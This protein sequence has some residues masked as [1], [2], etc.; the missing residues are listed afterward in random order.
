MRHIF[1]IAIIASFM[2]STIAHAG[3]LLVRAERPDWFKMI[4]QN[5]A[6]NIV[7]EGEIDLGAPARVAEALK[8]AG[9]D[10]ADV[11]ISSPWR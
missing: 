6:W 11:Y 2:T 4:T 8:K 5:K 3:I 1:Q 9:S 7:L 10:G